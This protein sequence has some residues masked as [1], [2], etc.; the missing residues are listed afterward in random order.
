MLSFL[1]VVGAL[2]AC[3]RAASIAGLDPVAFADGDATFEVATLDCTGLNF[4]EAAAGD[5]LGE[6][7][8]DCGDAFTSGSTW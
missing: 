4:T 5:C 2:A 6:F 8:T 1:V 7:H 3:A